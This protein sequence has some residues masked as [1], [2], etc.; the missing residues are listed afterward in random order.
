MGK[1]Q[2]DDKVL[3]SLFS[4][5]LLK[6]PS[7]LSS[8]SDNKSMTKSSLNILMPKSPNWPKS[9]LICGR[10]LIKPPKTDYKLS[11]NKTNKKL[12]K[13]KLLILTNTARLRRRKRK[14]TPKNNEAFD[15]LIHLCSSI[16][17]CYINKNTF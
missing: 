6:E 3:F 7:P 5:L 13:K 17:I 12:P 2:I 9:S 15:N 8:S 1:K 10:M 16:F 11:I 14:N 4:L